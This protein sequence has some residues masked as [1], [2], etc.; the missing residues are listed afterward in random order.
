E[1]GGRKEEEGLRGVIFSL[2][3]F[4]VGSWTVV[5]DGHQARPTKTH[6]IT[7]RQIPEGF[8]KQNKVLDCFVDILS[9]GV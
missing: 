6:E 9:G 4:R 5:I 1:G 8:I 2:V 7:P 3:M